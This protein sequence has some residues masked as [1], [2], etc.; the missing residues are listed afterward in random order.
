MKQ[1]WNENVETE[2]KQKNRLGMKVPR[3]TGI[4][5]QFRNENVET[6]QEPKK[7]LNGSAETEQKQILK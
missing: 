4:E 2:Q 1:F 5:K 7:V 3:R 6:E